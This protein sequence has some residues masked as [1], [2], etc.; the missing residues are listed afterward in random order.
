MFNADNLIDEYLREVSIIK[1]GKVV[2]VPAL[3]GLEKIDFPGVGTLEAFYT[4]SLR[5]LVTSFP[6]ATDLSEKTLRYP[7]HAEKIEF[8]KELGF[9]SEDPVMVQGVE[10]LQNL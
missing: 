5:S 6:G 9:F 2:Q 1:G 10:V 3:S 4:D 7:G 8:L